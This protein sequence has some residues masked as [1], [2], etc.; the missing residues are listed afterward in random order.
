MQKGEREEQSAEEKGKRMR[1]GK[2]AKL[3][4]TERKEKN[5][6]Q[7]GKESTRRR[8]KKGKLVNR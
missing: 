5:S 8:L 6:Q 7:R 1:R 3:V 2:K 4:N